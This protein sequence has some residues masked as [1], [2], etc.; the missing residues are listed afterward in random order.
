MEQIKS[1][2]HE[3]KAAKL[4][5]LVEN[6]P[7]PKV[8]KLW[9]KASKKPIPANIKSTNCTRVRPKYMNHKIFAVSVIFAVT[10]P[11]LGP[12]VSLL[13]RR[14]PPTPKSGKRATVKATIPMPPS[15]CIWH[16]HK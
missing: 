11:L 9:H 5:P 3:L 12:V 16:L 13:M 15:Q 6:P 1:I 8:A 2:C 7:V 14:K 10:F 4:A